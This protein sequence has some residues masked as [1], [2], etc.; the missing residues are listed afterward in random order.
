MLL[1]PCS[2]LGR[3]RLAPY[4]KAVCAS[5]SWNGIW[6]R[7]RLR[8]AGYDIDAT[9]LLCGTSGDTLEHRLYR[10]CAP[11]VLTARAGLVS[12]AFADVPDVVPHDERQRWLR[13]AVVHPAFFSQPI[14]RHAAC[15]I[16]V[17]DRE[18]PE[19]ELHLAGTF[20]LGGSCDRH[21]VA[22]LRRAGWGIA[23]VDRHAQLLADIHGPALYM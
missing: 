12:R 9:C 8:D 6:S 10:C 11:S 20:F 1:G 17:A 5:L 2:L 22:E 16:R 14:A 3:T 21:P 18:V 19:E 13:G 23:G 15:V 4:G 7:P